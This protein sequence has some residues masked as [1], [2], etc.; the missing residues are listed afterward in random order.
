MDI[1]WSYYLIAIIYILVCVLRF[2]NMYL[3]SD[4]KKSATDVKRVF[5]IKRDFFTTVAAACIIVTVAINV[6]AAIGGRPLNTSSMVITLLVIGFTLLNSCYSIMF[7]IADQSVSWIG[8]ELKKGDIE[9]LRIK[10]GKSKDTV[11]VN[12]TKDIDSYNYARSEEHTS[13]L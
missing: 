2:L 7:S 11:N 10:E 8:Y 4:Y 3:Q 1:K 6:A 9:K 12:F 5:T 13:E